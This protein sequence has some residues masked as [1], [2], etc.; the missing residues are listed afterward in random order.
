MS[1]RRADRGAGAKGCARDGLCVVTLCVVVLWMTGCAQ[2][3]TQ[4]NRTT[5]V[6]FVLGELQA[7][8]EAEPTRAAAAIGRVFAELQITKR[9][10]AFPHGNVDIV[11]FTPAE[12]RVTIVVKKTLANKSHIFIKVG[13]FGDEALSRTLYEKIQAAL[14]AVP[15]AAPQAPSMILIP[16]E[17]QPKPTP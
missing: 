7:P 15:A 6:G 11:G 17:L 5:G 1:R 8:L 4:A 12:K 14:S 9:Y 2:I 10:E 16:P 13:T 3:Y